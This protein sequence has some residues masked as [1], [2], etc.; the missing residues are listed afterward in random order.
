MQNNSWQNEFYGSDTNLAIDL[1]IKN[2][3][4]IIN[5]F[6]YLRKPNNKTK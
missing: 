5:D 6:N 2:I 1:F 3:I 4:I